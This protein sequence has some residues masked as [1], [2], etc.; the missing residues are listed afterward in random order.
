MNIT[1]QFCFTDKSGKEVNEFI[2]SNDKGT[3]VS[4]TNYG[5]IIT[6]FKIL[7]NNG[8]VNDI[9][10][11]FEKVEEYISKNYQ[12]TY[13]YFGCAV[14]RY[15]NRIKNACFEIDGQKFEVSKN[16][17][18]NQLHGGFEG[19]DK[20]VWEMVSFGQSP[21]PFLELKYLSQDG[22]EG[23]PGNLE[24]VA[25]FELNNE[26]E[27]S[28]VYTATCDKP[29]AVN[30]THHGYFNLKNGEGNIKDHEVK[31][32]GSNVLEQDENLVTNGNLLPVENTVFDFRE[33][34]SVEEGLKNIDEFDK[35]FVAD[36]PGTNTSVTL[37]GEVISKKSNLC[38]QVFSNEPV[39]HFYTGKWIPEIKGKNET[40]YGSFSGLCLE[41]QVHPNAIN[42]PHFPN[43]ILRPGEIYNKK[44]VYKVIQI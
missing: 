6:S 43:T 19:F 5:A 36:N 8:S 35:S 10:L 37:M 7:Q 16:N 24:V 33:F 42:I 23:Y 31:I 41:T 21:V 30:L 29:T 34:H 9:V 14:G 17:G 22:E 20:K 15:G 28:Y 27:L 13:P 4:I 44:T 11:G 40:I 25:R 2:L 39:V 38:L 32:Y 1:K 26:N 18:D 3:I 12:E